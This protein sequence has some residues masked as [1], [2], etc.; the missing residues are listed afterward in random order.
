MKFVKENKSHNRIIAYTLT[1]KGQYF[2]QTSLRR[3]FYFE[4]G[5]IEI[6]G[7]VYAN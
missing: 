2:L 6:E 3:W 7:V 1:K 5:R 4:S